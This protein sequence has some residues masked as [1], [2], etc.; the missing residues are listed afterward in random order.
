MAKL[1]GQGRQRFSWMTTAF[2]L[3]CAP[4]SWIALGAANDVVPDS[5][6]DGINIIDNNQLPLLDNRFRID[7][8]VKEITLLFFRRSGSPPVILVRPDGSKMYAT[9]AVTGEADWFDETTYDLIRIKNPMPGPWQ[10]IG[11]LSEGSKVLIITDFELNVDD[12]PEI[13]IQGET[14]KLTGYVTNN[15][16]PIRARNFKDVITLEVDFVSTNN[17]QYTN[18]GA[19]VVQVTRFV[20][21][22]LGFDERPKDGIFTG[23]FVLKFASGEWIPKYHIHT[24]LMTRELE[25]DPIL[26][27]PNPVNV[28]VITTD[29]PDEFHQLVINIEGDYVKKESMIFQGKIYYPNQEVQSFSITEN[30][31]EARIF[32]VINY[33]FGIYRVTMSAFGENTNGR[34]FMLE[35]PDFSLSDLSKVVR[36]ILGGSDAKKMVEW[37]TNAPAAE[38]VPGV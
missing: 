34:E 4:L 30:I 26:I 21:N 22:G 37:W 16:E 24:P 11:D 15:G 6:T 12:L 27:N 2:L 25:H 10:A 28:S 14:I 35:I 8:E 38:D 7:H 23:E 36:D 5:R 33:D 29:I 20:D 18:F 1:A 17:K 3:L 9:M 13:L 19:G 31:A 32:N